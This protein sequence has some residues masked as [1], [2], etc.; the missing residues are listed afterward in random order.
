MTTKTY[1]WS[2]HLNNV[3]PDI[4]AHVSDEYEDVTEPQVRSR[5]ISMISDVTSSKKVLI[6]KNLYSTTYLFEKVIVFDLESNDIDS[7]GR[8]SII[9]GYCKGYDLSA[10]DSWKDLEQKI[11]D[12]ALKNERSIS[13]NALS[14]LKKSF[15]DVLQKKTIKT[16]KSVMTTVLVVASIIVSVIVYQHYKEKFEKPLNGGKIEQSEPYTE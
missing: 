5:I 2:Q 9:T 14:D 11:K 13:D 10:N 8:K 4:M 7:G 15:G 12:F 16:R 3:S 1:L 6:A